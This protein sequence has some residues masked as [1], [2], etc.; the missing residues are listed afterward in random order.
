M[1]R[2]EGALLDRVKLHPLHL[3]LQNGRD[4][5][6]RAELFGFGVLNT[7]LLNIK[8]SID[9]GID[10]SRPTSHIDFDVTPSFIFRPCAL[11]S[12]YVGPRL[13]VEQARETLVHVVH[14]CEG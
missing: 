7:D 2:F 1:R 14:L 5:S 13:A 8:S 10:I 9:G 12:G 3:D 6:D 4:F 11:R